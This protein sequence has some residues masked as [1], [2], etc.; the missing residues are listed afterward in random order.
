LFLEK[1]GSSLPGLCS[2]KVGAGKLPLLCSAAWQRRDG[3]FRRG[4]KIGSAEV[5][6]LAFGKLP[7][8]K[9][10]LHAQQLFVITL[11]IASFLRIRGP[12]LFR[13]TSEQ[14]A[15]VG[16]YHIPTNLTQH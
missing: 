2:Y 11:S 6:K 13:C 7:L 8:V 1:L 4:R 9:Q 14:A 12:K 10:L 15:P 16:H 5:N 3:F